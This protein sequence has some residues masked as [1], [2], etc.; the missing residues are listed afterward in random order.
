M[1]VTECFSFIVM[2]EL[3]DTVKMLEALLVKGTY[4]I[5]ELKLVHILN[6]LEDGETFALDEKATKFLNKYIHTDIL[7]V[8][9]EQDSE[10]IIYSLN[11]RFN[12]IAHQL[13]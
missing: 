13:K 9:P 8:E 11:T 10:V 6:G 5:K 1:L 12:S 7:A 2:Y 3:S 4:L